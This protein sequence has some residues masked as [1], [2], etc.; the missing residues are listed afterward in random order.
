MVEEE[1]LLKELENTKKSLSKDIANLKRENTNL[2]K[3]ID[4]LEKS[5]LDKEKLSRQV[6]NK[7]KLDTKL[8]DIKKNFIQYDEIENLIS[9]HKTLN[10]LLKKFAELENQSITKK[11]FKQFSKQVDFLRSETASIISLKKQMTKLSL[12]EQ[13]LKLIARELPK[14]KT[15]LKK[16]K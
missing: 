14:I 11:Q 7:L 3:K 16:I 15:E 1:M 4:S 13:Q 9:K 6:I 10:L 8:S 2:K 5:Q 12:L